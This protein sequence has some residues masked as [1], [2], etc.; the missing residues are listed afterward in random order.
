MEMVNTT[1]RLKHLRDLMKKNKVDI[2]SRQKPNILLFHY[3]LSHCVVKLYHPKT[4]INPNML[5]RVM[6]AEVGFKLSNSS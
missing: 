5:Q 6:L 2:Y 1:E 3:T 4:A